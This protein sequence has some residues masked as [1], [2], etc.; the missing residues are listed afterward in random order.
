MS[1]TPSGASGH[2]LDQRTARLRVHC[3]Q[4]EVF[5]DL[6][7]AQNPDRSRRDP[8]DSGSQILNFEKRSH[9]CQS[10]EVRE[11]HV[12]VGPNMKMLTT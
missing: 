1:M 4:V 12:V 6:P 10:P 11:R 7:H 9:W 3:M 8:A 2:A 5:A